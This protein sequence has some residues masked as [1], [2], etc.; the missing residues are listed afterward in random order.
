MHFTWSDIFFVLVIFQLI[1][2]SVFL[3]SLDKGPRVSNALLGVFFLSMGLNLLDNF[4]LGKGVYFS[5]PATGL[6]S[7]WMLLLLGPLLYLYT[8]SVLYR[9]FCLSARKWLH[10]LPFGLLTLGTEGVYLLHSEQ[11]Q[12]TIQRDIL[13]HHLPDYFYWGSLVIFVQFFAYVIACFRIIRR[14]TRLAENQFSAQQRT[15]LNWLTSTI[16]FVTLVMLAAMF[17][18]L[19]GLTPWARYFYLFFT[20]LVIALF[21]F[22]NRVLFKAMRSPEIFAWMQQKGASEAATRSKYAGS[23]LGE[24]QSRIIVD[25]LLRHMLQRKPFL[26]PD[27]TLDQLAAQ[28]D[29]RPRTLSQVINERLNQNFFDFINRYRIDEAKNLLSHPVDKKITVLEVLYEVG[30]NSKSSFNT[31][32]K[33]YTGLTPSEFKRRNED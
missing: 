2:L 20:V 14:Y 22:I 31:L 28:L 24:E 1:F 33:K 17:I 18:G 29:L 7:V 12:R 27:L 5:H 8:Q 26:E 6:W 21:I 16:V 19:V 9:S 11:A 3:F 25:A 32:F 13:D 30:F 23:P 10:F 15:N 4:L